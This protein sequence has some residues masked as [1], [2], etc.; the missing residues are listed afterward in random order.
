MA[1][2]PPHGTLRA[3]GRPLGIVLIIVSALFFSTAGVFPK[4]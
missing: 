1:R 4:G 2:V 3:G